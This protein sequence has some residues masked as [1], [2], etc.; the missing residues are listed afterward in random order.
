M[1][2]SLLILTVL[3]TISTTMLAQTVKQSTGWLFLMNTAKFNEKWGTHLDVQFRSAD[4]FDYMKNLM[5]RPGVTYYIDNSN[6]VTLGY[7]FNNTYNQ[8]PGASNQTSTEH[9]IWQQYIYKHKIS[10]SNLTHRFRLEQRFI[11]RNL[12]DDLFSQRFRYFIRSIIPLQKNAQSF[13]KG[14]FAAL[15]NEVFLN[16]Q[17]KDQL[18]GNVFD[19]NRAYIAGGYRFSKK[20]D[21]ELGYMN[22]AVKGANNNT[23]NNIAQLAIYTRF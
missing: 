22:Q 12:N 11:E 13:D 4:R 19:Q 18:N 23:V 20:M 2:I 3:C 1:R 7:L 8:I 16:L 17:N 9:R 5:F 21:V 6:E 15:Q 10:S 14:P